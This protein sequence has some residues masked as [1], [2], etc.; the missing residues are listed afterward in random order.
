MRA[1]AYTFS[2]IKRIGDSRFIKGN[3][4]KTKGMILAVAVAMLAG[5]SNAPPSNIEIGQAI[6][7]QYSSTLTNLSCSENTDGTKVLRK[8]LSMPTEAQSREYGI[9]GIKAFLGG[10]TIDQ[11]WVMTCSDGYNKDEWGFLGVGRGSD[12][13]IH[14]WQ[15]P[16]AKGRVQF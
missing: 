11:I 13:K 1:G 9:S 5:C 8:F 3:T 6:Y 16:H 4:M 15:V 14:V 12:G 10:G 7:E 2:G